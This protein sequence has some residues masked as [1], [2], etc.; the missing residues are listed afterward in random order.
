MLLNTDQLLNDLD[1][2]LH[3]CL[4]LIGSL[5]TS[6]SL[7]GPQDDHRLAFTDPSGFG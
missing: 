1:I 3:S 5:I 4:C 6:V 2:Y 7:R